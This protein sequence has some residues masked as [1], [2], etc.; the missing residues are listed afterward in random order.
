[1]AATGEMLNDALSLY[2]AGYSIVADEPNEKETFIKGWSTYATKRVDRTIAEKWWGNGSKR[3]MSIVTGYKVIGLDFDNNVDGLWDKI[4]KLL[5]DAKKVPR[6]GRPDSDGFTLFFLVRDEKSRVWAKDGQVVM[7]LLAKGRKTTIPPSIHPN[8]AQ[9]EWVVSM[10]DGLLIELPE[11]FIEA[12]DAMFGVTQTERQAVRVYSGEVSTEEIERALTFIGGRDYHTWTDVGM[13][14]MNHLGYT[15]YSVYRDWSSDYEG[16]NERECSQKWQ[17][18]KRG[19][20]TIATIFWLAQQGGFVPKRNENVEPIRQLVKCAL[21][22]SLGPGDTLVKDNPAARDLLDVGGLIGEIVE[23]MVATAPFPQPELSLG[24]AIGLMSTILG[25]SI[26]SESGLRPNLY[27]MCIGDS[28]CGKDHP[29]KCAERLL[30]ELKLGHR[31]GSDLASGT[32]LVQSVERADGV[33]LLSIDEFGL[34]LMGIAAS[35]KGSSGHLSEI[36]AILMKF[37]S[38]SQG[39]FRGKEYARHNGKNVDVTMIKNPIVNLLGF[40]TPGRLY[41]A[42]GVAE[43]IDGFLNRFFLV[44][45]TNSSPK[46][47]VRGGKTE[48]PPALIEKLLK[49]VEV[50]NSCI[51]EENTKEVR[52][53]NGA[54]GIL[55]DLYTRVNSNKVISGI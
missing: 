36:P 19:G 37:F 17:S 45:S 48:P 1:M 5:P 34:F 12:L 44:I 49:I 3:N 23:W 2:D 55:E 33:K 10:E 21:F 25:K 11:G 31:I 24:A 4:L 15:G 8:G 26:E 52:C 39:T 47:N 50:A 29:R 40:T 42:L 53:S 46:R 7:E 22:E 14:L 16:F 28:G 27:T 35:R 51:G 43:C 13:A 6:K 38:S 30:E 54:A 9:Y 18:F 20:I 32:G 41:E